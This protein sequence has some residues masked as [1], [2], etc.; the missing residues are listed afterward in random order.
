MNILILTTHLNIGGITSYV[1]GLAEGLKKRGHNLY[2]ATSE[3][4]MEEEFKNNNI[5]I[6]KLP[7]KTKAEINPKILISAMMLKGFI[8][9][10]NIDIVHANTRVTQVLACLIHKIYSKP[11]VSTCH[12]F[13]KTRLLRRVFPCW[14][15]KII[16][17]SSQ[18]KEHLER[19]FSVNPSQICVIHN[20]ISLKDTKILEPQERG[21]LKRKFGLRGGP[22]IGIIA[23]LS[24]VKGHAYLIRAMAI[25]SR[26]IPAAQLLIVGEG[27]MKDEL[28]RLRR[29]LNLEKNIIFVPPLKD[30]SEAI[31]IMDLFVMPSLK[32]GLG[33]AL[34][35][36]MAEEVAV[37]GSAVGGI[38]TLINDG[39]N[40]LLVKPA[41][42][43]GL[44]Q[45]IIYLLSDD[46]KRQSLG[47]QARQFIEANFSQEKMCL[48]TERV[49]LQC[50]NSARR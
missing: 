33:L 11:Y 47:K 10:K 44:G 14:G 16:A 3:G 21:E 28:L 30:I 4:Q 25:V 24:D 41:D 49:Y 36:A 27:K 8:R 18:V 15:Q 12:G 31:S 9:S 43:S 13:F 5:E 29:E 22:V 50:T 37:I 6:I 17:I 32:E 48:E 45:K 19:D 1:L 38:K 23:R 26:K 2:V 34:M 20:G 46:A 42:I 40:G 7:I 35:E 39:L